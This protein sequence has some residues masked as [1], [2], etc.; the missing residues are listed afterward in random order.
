MKIVLLIVIVLLGVGVA[1]V[2]ALAEKPSELPPPDALSRM[3]SVLA[4]MPEEQSMAKEMKRLKK[5]IV[6]TM[7]KSM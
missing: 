4:A 1:A 7:P 3:D 2:F 5:E 6:K